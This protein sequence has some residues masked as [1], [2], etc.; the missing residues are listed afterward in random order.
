MLDN[1]QG[2][3][4][5]AL[6]RSNCPRLL[7]V[8]AVVM[9]GCSSNGG[10]I[11]AASIPAKEADLSWM[12]SED[13]AELRKKQSK[14]HRVDRATTTKNLKNNI[15]LQQQQINIQPDTDTGDINIQP[16][17]VDP[18]KENN[19]E[20]D[21]DTTS[22]DVV[23][24]VFEVRYSHLRNSFSACLPAKDPLLVT[25]EIVCGEGG[26]PEPL[27]T[28]ASRDAC[29]YATMKN[30][31]GE[32]Y[33][34]MNCRLELL[35]DTPAGLPATFH[36][37]CVAQMDQNVT[38]QSMALNTFV[39]TPELTEISCG[40]D[41][42]MSS[43]TT[44]SLDVLRI[45]VDAEIPG[46]LFSYSGAGSFCGETSCFQIATCYFGQT[47][48]DS[49]PVLEETV[50]DD[51]TP[52]NC[53]FS[54][55]S[56]PLTIENRDTN[57]PLFVG[58]L[59]LEY[60]V[61]WSSSTVAPCSAK[62][63]TETVLRC[64]NLGQIDVLGYEEADV[65]ALAQMGCARLS[66][67]SLLCSI[68]ITEI[69]SFS[70]SLEITC[71]GSTL[72]SLV[73]EVDW[74]PEYMVCS[75][76]DSFAAGFGSTG[77]YL[78][79]VQYCPSL[80][81]PTDYISYPHDRMLATHGQECTELTDTF[82]RDILYDWIDFDG[83]GETDEDEIYILAVESCARR[84]RNCQGDFINYCDDDAGTQAIDTL[85]NRVTLESIML[86]P[87]CRLPLAAPVIL[88]S[89]DFGATTNETTTD[90][91]TTDESANESTKE[92]ANEAAPSWQIGDVFQQP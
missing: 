52:D 13:A 15:G 33:E 24:A 77:H 55:D 63:I 10:G 73:L 16:D 12:Y 21:R 19:G 75:G 64:G 78:E 43:T 60:V 40:T 37:K 56:F 39:S 76:P 61:T 59:R 45:C 53:I 84:S 27:G 23:E 80:D 69:G 85:R 2:P 44:R 17:T 49:L 91:T 51:V 90:E 25:L 36:Y 88:D 4:S 32:A 62:Q 54:A 87:L 83:D 48:T 6:S 38:A 72:E 41:A 86:D 74:L 5:S 31:R 82:R 20:N 47:C 34:V 14:E 7:L 71:Q 29:E 66:K 35:T 65:E 67:S 68:D 58:G 89:A 79:I 9:A 50:W 26:Y 3:A 28:T 30:G 8:W 11:Q 81:P 1:M 70:G 42:F 18:N 22:G 92:S 46:S 57:T